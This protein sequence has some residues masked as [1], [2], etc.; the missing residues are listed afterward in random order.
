[1]IEKFEMKII[2]LRNGEDIICFYYA[3]D[4]ISWIKYPKLFYSN[5]DIETQKEELILVDWLS[6]SAYYYQEVQ[7]NSSEVLFS[8]HTNVAF[9]YSYLK[10][11]LQD[12]D[13]ESEIA[14]RIKKTIDLNQDL[15]ETETPKTFH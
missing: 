5:Y 8:T 6:K 15:E 2:K 13:P 10:M 1:M 9:G 14:K 11:L 7:I 12:L 4:N 3:K